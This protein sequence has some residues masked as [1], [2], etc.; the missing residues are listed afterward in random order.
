VNVLA[1]SKRRPLSLVGA[2]TPR[3]LNDVFDYS[4]T[5][6]D[7][8]FEGWLKAVAEIEEATQNVSSLVESPDS[9]VVEPIVQMRP[10]ALCPRVANKTQLQ[11]VATLPV[12]HALT[13]QDFIKVMMV[14]LREGFKHRRWPMEAVTKFL[15]AEVIARRSRDQ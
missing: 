6:L 11:S 2:S 1:Q 4:P 12:R 14:T 9:L 3:S 8:S 7:R 5:S 10:L 15:A 13:S